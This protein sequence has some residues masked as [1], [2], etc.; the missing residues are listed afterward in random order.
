MEDRSGGLG[1][2]QACLLNA[3]IEIQARA[4]GASRNIENV[5][6][7]SSASWLLLADVRTSA[8][9]KGAWHELDGTSSLVD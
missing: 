2:M 5:P 1:D 8:T 4:A 6:A 9:S 7:E 3:A